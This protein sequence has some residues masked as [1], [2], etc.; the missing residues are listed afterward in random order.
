MDKDLYNSAPLISVVM[1][2]YN[3]ESFLN[4]AIESVLNQ[5]FKNFEFLIFDDGSVDKSQEI[6]KSYPDKRIRAFFSEKNLG[7]VTHL[8]SGIKLAKGKYIARMD[9]DDICLPDRF[10][11]QIECFEKDSNLS[12]VFGKSILI[13]INDNEIC[14]SWRPNSLKTIL[15][16]LPYRSYIPHPTVMI[17]KEL[18]HK[19]NFYDVSKSPAEDKDLWYKFKMGGE[20]FFYLRTILIKYRINPNSVQNV[21]GNLAYNANYQ[22][23]LIDECFGNNAKLKVLNYILKCS[24]ELTLRDLVLTSMRLFNP[25]YFSVLRGYMKAR[26][27]EK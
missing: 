19:Y 6:I 13:D 5:S 17:K 8:N 18:F 16:F 21:K 7:Y 22:M 26:A 15:K 1:P 25:F 14:E 9:A 12:I 27:A 2:V 23:K 20:T 11:K 10:S 4:S 3:A 24:K